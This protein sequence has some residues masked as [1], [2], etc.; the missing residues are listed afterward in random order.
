LWELGGAGGNHL[1]PKK[2]GKECEMSYSQE[3]RGEAV[4]MFALP[5]GSNLIMIYYIP[6]YIS[7][8]SIYL[9]YD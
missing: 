2:N 3:C 5:R 7:K 9:E 1:S 4:V 6:D 8:G